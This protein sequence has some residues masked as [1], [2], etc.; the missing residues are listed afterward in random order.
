MSEK[1]D[2]QQKALLV[3]IIPEGWGYYFTPGLI[4]IYQELPDLEVVRKICVAG[5]EDKEVWVDDECFFLTY[6]GRDLNHWVGRYAN[7]MKT[8]MMVRGNET[9]VVV[10]C[11]D[12]VL[13]SKVLFLVKKKVS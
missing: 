4:V 7:L 11:Q 12:F 2:N 10:V 1:L 6:I 13:G 5:N 8:Q 3:S 9:L